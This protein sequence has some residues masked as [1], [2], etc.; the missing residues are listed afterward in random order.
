MSLLAQRQM[1]FGQIGQDNQGGLGPFSNIGSNATQTLVNISTL[2]SNL[3]AFFSI[4][5]GLWFG[6]QLFL[7][8]W[9]WLSSGG[10][11][12]GLETARNR[13]IHAIIG[14]IIV[15]F[16]IAIIGIIGTVFGLN[17]L[18][19]NPQEVCRQITNN[20]TACGAPETP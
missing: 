20:S 5:A 10:D 1:D 12:H 18:L 19:N 16:S 13:M 4:L 6:F 7:G 11:K 9:G 3:V 2:L 14:L 8:A 17:I 15:V